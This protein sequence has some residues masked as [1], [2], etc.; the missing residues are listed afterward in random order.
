M[1]DSVSGK[2]GMNRLIGSIE[3]KV[4]GMKLFKYTKEIVDMDLEGNVQNYNAFL[5]HEFTLREI[6]RN[7]LN[8][9]D[10]KD[11]MD[12]IYEANMMGSILLVTENA[13]LVI[14]MPPTLTDYQKKQLLLLVNKVDVDNIDIC[15]GCAKVYEYREFSLIND[16]CFMTY[17]ETIEEINRIKIDNNCSYLKKYNKGNIR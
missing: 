2:R 16:G 11:I 10:N 6:Y 8:D 17:N 1:S 3:N 5:G 9:V 7:K 12:I 14:W 13:G 4:K 15:V